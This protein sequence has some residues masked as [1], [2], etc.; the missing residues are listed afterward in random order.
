M[1]IPDLNLLVY[2]HNDGAPYHDSAKRWW[3]ALING[4]ERVGVP[5]IVSTGFV[6]LMT[7]PSVLT[8]PATPDEAVG[9]VQEWFSFPQVIAINPGTEHLSHFRRNLI[10]AGRCWRELGDRRPHSRG[11]NGV[12]G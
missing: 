2:A 8:H 7:H 10:A 5:W 9:F 11:G 6:R 3:E 1:I 12:P 4:S